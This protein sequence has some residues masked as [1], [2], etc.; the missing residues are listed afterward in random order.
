MTDKLSIYQGACAAIGVRRIASLSED[1]L[2]LRELNGVFDRGGIRTCLS[3]GY[4]KF[5]TRTQAVTYDPSIEPDFGYQRAFEKSSDWILTAGVSGNENF[6]PPLTAYR[7]EGGF[8]FADLDTLYVSFIS[9]DT[10]FGLDYSKWPEN[11]ARYAEHWFGLQ[12]HERL[13]ND[14]NKKLIVAQETKRLLIETKA[15]DA[16]D[17]PTKFLPQGTWSTSRRGNAVGRD[18][19]SRTN[20]IG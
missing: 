20:L 18:R 10:D 8:L 3:T 13:V 17:G 19:G 11:F 14:T 2:S 16:L 5:A 6:N 7:D 15:K 12:V 9:D 1:R 4:Y